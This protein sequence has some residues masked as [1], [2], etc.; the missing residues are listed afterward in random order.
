MA[1]PVAATGPSDAEKAM[2]AHARSQ[3]RQAQEADRQAS[4]DQ[5]AAARTIGWLLD[6]ADRARLLALAPPIYGEVVADHVTLEHKAPAH[7]PLPALVD[8]RVVGQIDDGK[9]VQALVVSIGGTTD[10][11][12]GSTYHMTWSLGPGRR[13]VESNAVLAELGW[14]PL[15]EDVDIRLTPA[16]FG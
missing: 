8:A 13:A 9:G 14:S 10:R 6:R 11:P 16:S 15:A 2:G 4:A 12:D 1:D 3:I 7:R 5:P